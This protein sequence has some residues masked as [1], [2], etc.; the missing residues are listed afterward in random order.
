V[1]QAPRLSAAAVARYEVQGFLG[2]FTLCPPAQMADLRRRLD[3][4]IDGESR[5]EAIASQVA[6]RHDAHRPLRALYDRHLTDAT[7][8]ALAAHPH[9]V[10]L[11]TRLLGENLLLWRTTF[12]IKEPHG[13]RLEWHQDTYKDE[14]FGSFANLNAWIAIDE[15]T[16]RNGVRLVPGTQHSIIGRDPFQAAD[17]VEALR[18]TEDLPAPPVPGAELVTMALQP[19]QF[20][21]FDG[22]VLHG[23]PPNNSAQR[24]AGFVTRF[25]P[26]GTRLDGLSSPSILVAG[27]APAGL[28]ALASPPA[29]ASRE[30]P[31]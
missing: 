24:R 19:G 15:A 3:G 8:Y 13:R 7:V 10:A 21:V 11:A 5:Q 23:S 1:S 14:G 12:W 30:G 2:P 27:E 29:A 16:E 4:A 28:H 17:Y 26:A 31:Q 9:I 20:F 22:R 25:I 6:P 18:A